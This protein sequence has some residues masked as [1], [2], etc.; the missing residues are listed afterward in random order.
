[1]FHHDSLHTWDHMTWEF[2]TAYP[3]LRPD[4]VLASDDIHGAATL[5]EILRE[6]AFPAFCRRHGVRYASFF[7]LGIGSASASNPPPAGGERASWLIVG[8]PLGEATQFWVI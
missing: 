1:M 2:E 4:G 8:W 7:N 3:H 5:R 6:N